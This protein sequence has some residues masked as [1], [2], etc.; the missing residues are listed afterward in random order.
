V[1]D[2]TRLYLKATA[3]QR[4]KDNLLAVAA[5]ELR[6]P[7][8]L[9]RMALARHLEHEPAARE[10]LER[11]IARMTRLI[12]DLVDFARNEQGALELHREWIDVHHF[13]VELMDD[14]RTTFDERKVRLSVSAPVGLRISADRHRIIQVFSNLL[15]NALKFT[16]AGG[17]VTIEAVATAG[18]AIFTVR[19]SG[20]G[21]A[22]DV[23]PRVLDLPTNLA[24]PHG[25]GIGLSVSRRVVELHGGSIT[26]DSAGPGHGTL[27]TVT[28]PLHAAMLGS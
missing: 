1:R 7:L 11:Y 23:L 8:H 20:R 17:A 25:L 22:A 26:V 2:L 10:T 21:L 4:T 9:L 24:S 6:H 15:D 13:L 16:P 3:A 5:H 28:L 18:Q 19:D 14:Y 27:V 12:D